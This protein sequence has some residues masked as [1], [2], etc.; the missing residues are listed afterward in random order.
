MIEGG[1]GRSKREEHATGERDAAP[2]DGP[3]DAP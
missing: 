2:I 3:I 1:E